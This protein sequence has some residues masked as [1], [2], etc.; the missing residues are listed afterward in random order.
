MEILRE[1]QTNKDK[2][3]GYRQQKVSVAKKPMADDM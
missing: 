1:R 3:D 2:K